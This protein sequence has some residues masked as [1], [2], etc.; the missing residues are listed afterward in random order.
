M[1]KLGTRSW[2]SGHLFSIDDVVY[3]TADVFDS[4][5]SEKYSDF[6]PNK[7][8]TILEGK[9]ISV[10]KLTRKER[11]LFALDG[12]VSSLDLDC[13]FKHLHEEQKLLL[14]TGQ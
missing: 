12:T 6:F 5:G 1:Q 2:L 3:V 14:Y 9:I 7:D 11:V 8:K 10:S 4:L 13:L